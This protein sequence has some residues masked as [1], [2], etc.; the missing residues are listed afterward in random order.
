MSLKL[1]PPRHGKSPNYTI[2]GTYLKVRV[3]RTSGTADK[4]LARRE[5]LRIRQQIERDRFDGGERVRT[6]ATAAL[7]YLRAGGARAFLEPLVNLFENTPLDAIGQ[8]D[9]DE[10]AVKLY[11]RATAAT[12]NRQ[13]YTPVSAIRRHAGLTTPLRR[14]KG[15]AGQVRVDWIWPEEA[16]V[17]FEAA[18]RVDEEFRLF[19]ILLTYCGPRLSELLRVRVGDVRLGE[20]FVYCGRTKNGDPRPMHLPP[21]AVAAIASHPRG[22]L[23]PAGDT[24]FRFRKNGALYLFM[25]ETRKIAQL[26]KH[27]T[28]H[29]LRHTWATWMRRYAGLDAKA[30]VDTGAWRDIKSASRYAHVVVS[31]EAQKADLLPVPFRG[32]TLESG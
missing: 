28:F 21:V 8:E 1:V 5:L 13:V 15:A 19:L 31:E 6:F 9:I 11:P 10:A 12:R 29:T 7:S 27:V 30:L 18:G 32:K 22:L 23:R 25:A 17:L 20:A 2:R 3:D 14:P 4:A 16:G 26:T 24:L